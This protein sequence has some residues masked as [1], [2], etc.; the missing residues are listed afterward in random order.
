MT[1]YRGVM[2]VALST[3]LLAACGGDGGEGSGA[4]GEAGAA[5]GGETACDSVV[6]TADPSA[7]AAFV[8]EEEGF[9]GDTNVKVNQVGNDAVN[10]SLLAGKSDIAWMGPM[11]AADFASQGEGFQYISTA[12]ALNMWNAIVVREE[13]GDTYQTMDDLRG[14]KVGF[15][16]FGGGDYA[17]LGAFAKGF[18]EIDDPAQAFKMV[19]ADSGALL[20]LLE[21]GDIDAALLHSADSVA[22]RF[23]DN[24][25][26][27]FSFTELAQEQVGVPLPITGPVATEEWIESCPDAVEGVVAG[28]DKGVEYM[29]Q[30]PQEF[31]KGGK[32]EDLASAAG[33]Y[34][35]PEALAGIQELLKA[36]EF[37]LSS[38][39][40][41]S[42]WRDGIH[43][44]V[45]AGEGT[46]VA[47]V[48][49]KDAYLRPVD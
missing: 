8:A 4:G 28:L 1:S 21:K 12:G 14:K 5:G 7:V 25:E 29:N 46:L 3:V 11:E 41:T 49:E 30:N 45:K 47:S 16:G 34:A 23:S 6:L 18:F 10:A 38:D 20:A 36:G 44:I 39:A 22:V 13:D 17:T 26:N 32:Y 48:P 37:T 2:V 33:W 24:F 35:N 43:E 40:Y 31:E 15:H 9:F 42:E 19:T 27:V